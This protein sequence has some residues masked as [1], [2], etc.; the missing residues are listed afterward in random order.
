MTDPTL[1][2]GPE[3]KKYFRALAPILSAIYICEDLPFETGRF[4]DLMPKERPESETLEILR[5]IKERKPL[6][7]AGRMVMSKQGLF[8]SALS[9]THSGDVV[10]L[11]AGSPEPV[12]LRWCEDSSAYLLIGTCFMDPIMI[13]RGQQWAK[14]RGLEETSIDIC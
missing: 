13:G 5:S 6:L 11:L 4:R 10:C 12:I 3:L 8:G 14:E 1:N 9:H 7:F 2:V